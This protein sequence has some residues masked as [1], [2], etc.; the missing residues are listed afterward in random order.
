M[1]P[2]CRGLQ[3]CPL[4]GA[5]SCLLKFKGVLF[6]SLGNM[7]L[8]SLAPFEAGFLS[9]GENPCPGKGK[10]QLSMQYRGFG[11]SGDS[12]HGL[13]TLLQG[14]FLSRILE[15]RIHWL[16]LTME[17]LIVQEESISEIQR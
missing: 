9:L 8:E 4:A 3:S 6:T 1:S 12:C 10:F 17:R 14:K 13:D 7:A 11:Q 15:S 5:G 16:C 2:F